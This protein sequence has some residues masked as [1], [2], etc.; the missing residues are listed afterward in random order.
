MISRACSY[1]AS[2][3]DLFKLTLFGQEGKG[4]EIEANSEDGFVPVDLWDPAGEG[5]VAAHTDGLVILPRAKLYL[6]RCS[7][8]GGPYNP[9]S[10]TMTL[11]ILINGTLVRTLDSEGFNPDSV[12][13][14]FLEGAEII[15]APA[16]AQLRI[17]VNAV[18]GNTSG[19][20]APPTSTLSIIE[21]P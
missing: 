4:F 20:T 5:E 17:A 6:V 12:S 16:N 8:S 7:I 10:G 21:L 19:G 11:G 18:L 14:A 9:T 13:D 1:S 15:K 3:M 2:D